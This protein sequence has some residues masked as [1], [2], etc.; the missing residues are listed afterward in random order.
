MLE[1]KS[2]ENAKSF[3]EVQFPVAKVSAESYKERKSVASQTLTGLG[4]W[5]GRKPLVM[6][7]A[8]LLGLLLPAS[9]DAEKDR[10]VFLKLMT[11][12]EAGLRR[13]LNKPISNADM[14]EAREYL[15][16]SLQSRY[17]NADGSLREL[18]SEEKGMLREKIFEV[19]PYSQK[20]RYCQRPEHLDGPELAEWTEINQHL[21][22]NAK[23]LQELVLELGMARFGRQP[24]VGDCFAGGGSIPF[25][26][27]RLGF[28]AY[29]A[30]LNPVAG[31]LTWASLNI[32]GGGEVKTND[33]H[34]LQKQIYTEVDKKIIEL[35]I[36]NNDRGWRS[37]YHLYCLEAIDP[38]NG[39]R[40]PLLGNFV[41]SSARRVILQLTPNY[42]KK[43]FDIR[44]IQNAT[45]EEYSAAQKKFTVKNNRLYSPLG[46]AETDIQ[47]IRRNMRLWEN[48]DITSRADDVFVE[49]LYCVRWVR[50]DGERVYSSVGPDDLAREQKVIEEVKKNFTEWQLYGYIPNRRIEAGQKTDEPI[51]TR[52]YTQWHHL[53]TPRQLLLAGLLSEEALAVIARIPEK[54]QENIRFAAVCLALSIG[55]TANYSSKLSVWNTVFEKS[56]QTF[57]NQA[58]NTLMNFPARGY[59]YLDNTYVFDL[60]FYSCVDSQVEISDAR[61]VDH[62]AEYWITD[63]PYADAVNYDEISEF[64]LAWQIP[65]LRLAFPDWPT[66]SRRELSV[67]GKDSAFR[68]AM[69][70]SYRRLADN[71]PEN[72]MQVGDVHAHLSEGMGGSGEHFMG[73]WVEGKRGVDDCD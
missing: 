52:G 43:I 27:A 45:D 5:K 39:W 23:S 11:M 66:D 73:C 70:Q 68:Q 30:D 14:V 42:G 53:F 47:E 16:V 50:Q 61:M 56:E 60:D 9:D 55:R 64:F 71:M 69:A 51:R 2:L 4:N 10:K 26:A 57:Y 37:D 22:T 6:V 29:A 31:L 46:T 21:G 1:P 7:R 63:P 3:I 41:I 48:E 20:L 54:S 67:R 38:E 65:Y 12:D 35:G 8:A 49:R 18:G 44:I 28:E 59:K 72:G 40:T 24:R 62:K 34:Q 33:Q 32:V 15:P 36:E 58:L 17:Y 13:R 19:L 25:E